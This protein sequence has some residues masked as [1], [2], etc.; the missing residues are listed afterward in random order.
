MNRPRR[1]NTSLHTK[2]IDNQWHRWKLKVTFRDRQWE[3][4]P[5]ARAEVHWRMRSGSRRRAKQRRQVSGQQDSE[6]KGE[7]TNS[8]IWGLGTLALPTS[9]PTPG[10]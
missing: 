9:I 2:T 8:A 10:E 4:L 7:A 5:G 3:D 1:Y 6:G